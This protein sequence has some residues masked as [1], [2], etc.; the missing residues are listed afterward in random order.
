MKL[1][2]GIGNRD[3]SDDGVGPVVVES[4][5]GIAAGVTCL[6]LDGEPS[7]IVEAWREADLAVVV[8][9]VRTGAAP[10]TLHQFVPDQ[11]PDGLTA[12]VSSHGSGLQEAIA[13]GRLLDRLPTRLLVIGVEAADVSHGQQLSAP[14]LASV[15]KARELALA[16]LTAA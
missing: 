1:L 4:A 6:T 15:A 2:L 3:R 14:V 8:D 7:R 9:A 5:T 16:E 13:M 10:G 12:A 11:L